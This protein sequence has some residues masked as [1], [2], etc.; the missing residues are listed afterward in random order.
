MVSVI[1]WIFILFLLLLIANYTSGTILLTPQFGFIAC[2]IPQAIYALF[3]VDKWDLQLSFNTFVVLILGCGSFLLVSIFMER[4]PGGKTKTRFGIDSVE[5]NS[6]R[7][8]TIERWKIIALLLFQI[9]V[10]ALMLRYIISLPGGSFAEKL[11]FRDYTS[12]RVEGGLSEAGLDLPSYLSVARAF[13]Y[14]SGFI[15]SYLLLHGI[16]YKYKANRGLLLVCFIMSILSSLL[17]GQRFGVYSLAV[18]TLVQWYFIRGKKNNWGKVFS[19][20]ILGRV[21]VIMFMAMFLFVQLGNF[22]GKGTRTTGSDYIAT[23]LAAQLKNLDTYVRAGNFGCGIENWQTLYAWVNWIADRFGISSWKHFY[24]QPFYRIN[25]YSLGNVST[26]F[27]WFLH[28]GS[29]IGVI[30]FSSLMAFISHLVFRRAAKDRKKNKID[31]SLVVYSYL[32]YGIV[33]SFY[34][35]R[36]YSALSP[37][38][39]KFLLSLYILRWY[40]TKVRIRFGKKSVGRRELTND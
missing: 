18:A 15:T 24:D 5:A 7:Q 23:Y 32:F 1:F 21:L 33:F 35:N 6:N 12:K 4:L 10:V 39:W 28:D 8:I 25:G 2:F 34:S 38:F 27:Y 14:Y 31:L 9:V 16:I 20:K 26:V 29:Y 40:F 36:F 30:I 19:P 11:L 13:S 17:L 3:Y 22:I 37:D